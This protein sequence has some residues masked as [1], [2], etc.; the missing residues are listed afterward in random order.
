VGIAALLE[1]RAPAVR[2]EPEAATHKIVLE[3]RRGAHLELPLPWE[4]G[5]AVVVRLALL[6]GIDV[7]APGARVGKRA[8]APQQIIVHGA[9]GGGHWLRCTPLGAWRRRS[10]VK[11]QLS[12][13]L[14]AAGLSGKCA[15]FA[16]C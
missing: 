12:P 15:L 2:V 6:A 14:H 9:L 16:R 7:L 13:T 1:T 4:V 10:P 5:D 8:G 11:S 3:T